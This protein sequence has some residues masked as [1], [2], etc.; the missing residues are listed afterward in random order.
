MG[1]FTFFRLMSDNM[2]ARERQQEDKSN[3][4]LEHLMEGKGDRCISKL[5]K[6]SN[7]RLQNIFRDARKLYEKRKSKKIKTGCKRLISPPTSR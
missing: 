1:E 7:N 4:S 5:S 2:Q 6:T 3:V